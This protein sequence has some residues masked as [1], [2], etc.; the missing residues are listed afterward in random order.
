MI[1]KVCV[2][3]FLIT[4]LVYVLLPAIVEAL[5]AFARDIPIGV[6]QG[7]YYLLQESSLLLYGELNVIR[8]IVDRYWVLDRDDSIG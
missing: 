4:I 7:M 6:L 3:G 1:S 5:R 2:D 8:N